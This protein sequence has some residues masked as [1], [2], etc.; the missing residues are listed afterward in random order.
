M[1]QNNGYSTILILL[2]EAGSVLDWET[3]QTYHLLTHVKNLEARGLLTHNI[4]PLED[5]PALRTQSSPPN[6]KFKH[7]FGRLETHKN[8]K[9]AFKVIPQ[10]SIA[11]LHNTELLCKSFSNSTDLEY[12]NIY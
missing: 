4:D 11:A 5:K 1:V 3:T 2:K 8:N 7:V 12:K 10:G 9:L 6:H